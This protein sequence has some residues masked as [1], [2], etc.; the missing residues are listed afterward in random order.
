MANGDKI[1]KS[2]VTNKYNFACAYN[3]FLEMI[4]VHE[5]RLLQLV[6]RRAY[7]YIQI[8]C[9]SASAIQPEPFSQ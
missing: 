4:V 7:R 9:N 3:S 1:V 5:S 2:G 8:E 6:Y